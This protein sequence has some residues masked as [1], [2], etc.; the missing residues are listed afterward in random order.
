MNIE[1]FDLENVSRETLG[2]LD[3]FAELLSRWNHKIN[4][5]APSDVPNLWDRHIVDSI[6]IASLAPE[7]GRE[8]LDLGSGGGFPGLICAAIKH[9]E[10]QDI[11][12]SL[13]DSDS[14]KAAFLREAAR[15]MG[16]NVKVLTSRIEALSPRKADIITAR[17][18]APLPKLLEYCFPFCHDGTCLIF[19]KGRNAESE[20]TQ[21]VSDWSM[22]VERIPSR[23]DS[24]SQILK[25]RSLGRRQ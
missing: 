14:R 19:P 11:E 2:R 5:I 6:Q 10:P 23:T 12:F 18:L 9:R 7:Y 20:L 15:A 21:C 13:V 17:A 25:I 22:N 8:W 16:L 24:Q 1:R 4:L 3:V